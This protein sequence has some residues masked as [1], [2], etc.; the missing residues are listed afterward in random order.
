MDA[1]D[2]IRRLHQH[3]SWATQNL[4]DAAAKLSDEKL[5]AQFEIG[6]GSVWKSLLHMQGAEYVWLETLLGNVNSPFFPATCP[7]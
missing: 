7:A 5:R 6:Q 2:L 3:R 4:L 1:I